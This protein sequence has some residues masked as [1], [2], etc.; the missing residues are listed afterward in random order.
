MFKIFTF[1]LVTLTISSGIF[2]LLN[3]ISCINNK[4]IQVIKNVSFLKDL[5]N[6]FPLLL[7]IFLVRSFIFEPFKIPTGSMIP[8]L[9]IGDLIVVKKFAYNIIDPLFYNRIL[10][11]HKPKRGDIVVFKYP[12]NPNIFYIKRIIGI[13]GDKIIYSFLTKSLSIY[14]NCGNIQYCNNKLNINYSNLIISNFIQ[15]FT[16]VGINF[17]K[18]Y[19][20]RQINKN[21]VQLMQK[22]E[23]L[24]N[25][26]CYTILINPE[27]QDQ[28]TFY[29]KQTGKSLA[30]WV[31]PNNQYFVMGDNR[32]Y[33]AD[34]RYWGFV[35]EEYLVGKATAIWI[36]LNKK[37]GKWPT[38]I[39]LTRIGKI[40]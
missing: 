5:S 15:T 32:D 17:E 7:C 6:I 28:L 24:G 10:N 9:L 13:P 2:W 26:I 30:E 33:S 16:D 14:P 36:S 38:G 23:N 37:E 35:P 29:Y 4:Q 34:S 21:F 12:I 25:N 31:V 19:T 18:I 20:N 40:H 3:K 39:N 22:K 8:T 11:I 27:K 1:F